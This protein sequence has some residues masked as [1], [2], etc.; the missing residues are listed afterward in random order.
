MLQQVLR[1]ITK[2]KL[3]ENYKSQEI[4]DAGDHGDC[5][6]LESTHSTQKK[7]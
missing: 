1:Q 6:H 3:I 5:Q 4:M 7:I 2:K